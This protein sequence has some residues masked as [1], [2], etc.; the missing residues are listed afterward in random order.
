MPKGSKSSD[1]GSSAS[2]K[3]PKQSKSPC[4]PVC[5]GPW[6]ST[7]NRDPY[8]GKLVYPM[9]KCTICGTES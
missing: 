9:K 4:D 3:Q 5:R 1:S 2:P 7:D 8:T 6:K